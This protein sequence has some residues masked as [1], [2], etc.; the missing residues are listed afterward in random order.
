MDTVPIRLG[1]HDFGIAGHAGIVDDDVEPAEFDDGA[2]D[3]RVDAG[4]IAAIG[5]DRDRPPAVAG[6]FGG[7]PVRGGP[8]DVG[9]R[10]GR[11][12]CGQR[13]RRR[14]PIPAPAPV[15]STTLFCKSAI[16]LLP[17]LTRAPIAF[18]HDRPAPP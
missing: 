7:G 16:S 3:H 10:D 4:N 6:R 1:Q 12:G 9:R 15:T 17:L 14:R 8:V 5:L 13:E 18:W 11:P 2:K